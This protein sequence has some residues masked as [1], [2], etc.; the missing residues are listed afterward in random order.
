MAWISSRFSSKTLKMPVEMELLVPQQ[1]MPLKAA[2]KVLV[3]LHA[4]N[5]DRTEWLLKSQIEELVK[6]LPLLVVMPSGKNSSFVNTANGYR[7]MDFITQELPQFLK[8]LFFVSGEREDWLI[9][10]NSTG[11]YG[12]LHC[13]L[14]NPAVFGAAA[15]FGCRA[16]DL[17]T[18]NLSERP[19]LFLCCGRQ[20]PVYESNVELYQKLQNKYDVTFVDGEG[21]HDFL[22]WNGELKTML[23]WFLG[24]EVQL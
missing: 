2:L 7:Y 14:N 4:E 6:D 20:D 16:D 18:D 15:S 1:Q 21:G 11:G 5:R 23:S 24:K 9:A 3:L 12:A 22:Y 8:K 17:K 10:G 19:K 13:C